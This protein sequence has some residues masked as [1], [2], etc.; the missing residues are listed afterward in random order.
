MC[1]TSGTTGHP[2][3]VVYTHRSSLLHTMASTSA[4][5]LGCSRARPHPAG[6]ADV[7]RQR[8]GPGPRG[9]ATGADLVMPGPDLSPAG[10]AGC[11]EAERVTVA[12]GV[13]TIWMGLLDADRRPRPLEPARDPRVRRVGGAPGALG[14][15]PRARSASRSPR[16]WGMTETSPLGSVGHREVHPRPTC[17]EDAQADLRATHRPARRSASS[18]GS[19]TR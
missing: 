1:Y 18:C 14:G 6:R 12:A 10:A 13:P 2:K 19:S 17:D 15:L 16:R 11:I 8:L 9:V 5:M 3:G 4:D 7:P